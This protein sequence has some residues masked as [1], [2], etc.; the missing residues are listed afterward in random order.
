MENPSAVPAAARAR[1]ATRTGDGAASTASDAAAAASLAGGL[2]T[3]TIAGDVAGTLKFLPG[4]GSS[5]DIEVSVHYP[6]GSHAETRGHKWHVHQT[7]LLAPVTSPV[8]PQCL[9]AGG[10]WDPTGQEA[11]GSYRCIA[12]DT[13]K[14]YAGDL[15]GMTAPLVISGDVDRK[16]DVNTH[17]HTHGEHTAL[18]FADLKGK[19]IVIHAA[20]GGS[21]RIACGTI[22]D[23]NVAEE[24]DL[25]YCAGAMT[26]SDYIDSLISTCGEFPGIIMTVLL[27][28]ILGRRPML[29][30]MYGICAMA[31]VVIVPCI[32]RSAETAVFFVAR[33]ASN[34]FFQGV[35]LY[36]NEI[37][38]ANVRATGMGMCSAVA[39]VGL[40]S[41][42]FVA[43]KLDSINLT[44]A[45]KYTSNPSLLVVYST[46]IFLTD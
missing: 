40:I 30:Y 6:D 36:T 7:A 4:E 39:R 22:V 32:G 3:A 24:I 21:D 42:P 9:A 31:F 20:D 34:G 25:G 16:Q 41:T 46:N 35:Y 19:S 28:D 18:Q 33:G 8:G 10:H 27:I 43:Q 2:L 5:V 26:A 37:Y 23:P 29:A 45:S 13:S 12:F 11:L 17:E 15:S 38:P 44:L 14:C 1:A